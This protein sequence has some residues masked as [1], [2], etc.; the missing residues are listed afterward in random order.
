MTNTMNISAIETRYAGCRFR[1]RLEARWA[2]FFDAMGIKWEY[3]QQ[4]YVIKAKFDHAKP[5]LAKPTPYLPDFWLPDLGFWVEV[6]GR[7]GD[8]GYVTLLLEACFPGD[9]GG[10]PDTGKQERILLL[11]PIPDVRVSA[12]FAPA[13]VMLEWDE[14]CVYRHYVAFVNA[15]I[16]K[17]HNVSEDRSH[18]GG[19]CWKDDSYFNERPWIDDLQVVDIKGT[20]SELCSKPYRAYR[21]ARSARFE[22]G[23]SS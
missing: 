13:H 10:L 12:T 8:L 20:Y 19:D 1:S 21:A 7:D 18:V 6:K 23:E 17:R 14:G 3:E 9:R 11:G 22:H 4:G 5:W 16:S 15:G 2:V